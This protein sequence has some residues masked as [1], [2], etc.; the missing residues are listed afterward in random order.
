M[1][2]TARTRL[3]SIRVQT[4]PYVY[5]RKKFL[6]IPEIFRKKIFRNSRGMGEIFISY[7]AFQYILT[8]YKVLG[9]SYK[10]GG[11]GT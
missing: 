4:R 10:L 6:S 3:S 5:E 2:V 11:G 7:Q 8:P 1:Y 9:K